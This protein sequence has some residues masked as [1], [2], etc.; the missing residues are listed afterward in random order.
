MPKHCIECGGSLKLQ[1]M[2]GR[3]LSGKVV[4]KDLTLLACTRCTNYV[5]KAGEAKL[6]DE[7]LKD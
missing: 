5:I 2:K 4:K 6:I 1:N 7:A 3:K